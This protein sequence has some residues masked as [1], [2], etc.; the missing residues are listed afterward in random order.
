MHTPAPTPPKSSSL[1]PHRSMQNP[2]YFPVMLPVLFNTA[3]P[4]GAFLHQWS[5]GKM[6]ENPVSSED[7]CLAVPVLSRLCLLIPRISGTPHFSVG[8]SPFWL[9][10]VFS[11]PAIISACQG[12]RCYSHLRSLISNAHCSGTSSWEDLYSTK[13]KTKLEK[14]GSN[15]ASPALWACNSSAAIRCL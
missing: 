8:T 6:D 1:H 7:L 5:R 2:P 9:L 11:L 14:N 3:L 13:K 15:P 10:W 12:C 4:F